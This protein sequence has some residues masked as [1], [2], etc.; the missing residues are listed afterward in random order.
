MQIQIVGE[1]Y[2]KFMTRKRQF[3]KLEQL[4]EHR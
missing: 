3:Y 2:F 4:K 1:F